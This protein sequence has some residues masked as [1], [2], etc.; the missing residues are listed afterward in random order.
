MDGNCHLG[1]MIIPED[2]NAQ[3]ANGKLFCEFIERNPHLTIINSLNICDGK[4]TRIR[5]TTKGIEKSI[6]DVFVTCDKIL[7][8]ITK[9]Q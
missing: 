8:F 7:P 6:L 3:N 2:L 5:K 1:P 9:W 4:I